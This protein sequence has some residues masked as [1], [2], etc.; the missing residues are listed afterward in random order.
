ML[1]VQ[2]PRTSPFLT[3]YIENCFLETSASS[4]RSIGVASLTRISLSLST[5]AYTASQGIFLPSDS[6]HARRRWVELA[7]TAIG[8]LTSI[9]SEDD[10][11][12]QL[13]QS[14]VRPSSPKARRNQPASPKQR[15]LSKATSVTSEREA[16]V[17]DELGYHTPKN[18][19]EARALAHKLVREQ[20]ALMTVSF[21][22]PSL[23]DLSRLCS[24]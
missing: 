14:S 4:N 8:L 13:E 12:V 16:S 7:S 22:S 21:I 17:I 15:R 20:M 3:N 24:M 19:D 6:L 23:T 2:D 1:I 11:L 5:L 10:L 9:K 18:I